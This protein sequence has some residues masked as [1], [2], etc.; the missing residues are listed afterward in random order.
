MSEFCVIDYRN[1]VLKSVDVKTNK[2]YAN[3]LFKFRFEIEMV[4]SVVICINLFYIYL[5]IF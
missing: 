5:V 1:R 2:T 3:K 4:L